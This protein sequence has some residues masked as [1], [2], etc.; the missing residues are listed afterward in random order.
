MHI[1]IGGILKSLTVM[2][3]D[4]PANIFVQKMSAHY[5]C[6]I[7]S[8]ASQTLLSRVQNTMTGGP[9]ALRGTV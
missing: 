8:N 9:N 1:F 5:V 6:C 7:R 4:F 2:S 3:W